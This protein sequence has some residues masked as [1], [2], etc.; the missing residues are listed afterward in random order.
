[1]SRELNYYRVMKKLILI[2]GL[3]TVLVII[4]TPKYL[5]IVDNISYLIN[6]DVFPMKFTST[7][8]TD[9]CEETCFQENEILKR[10]C[11][12]E[13]SRRSNFLF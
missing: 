9:Y 11:K 12:Q 1:M 4:T 13:C 3:V 8:K 5:D 2:G 6:V 7:I 10:L